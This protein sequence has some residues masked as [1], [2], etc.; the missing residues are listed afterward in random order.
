[1]FNK[2][3]KYTFLIIAVIAACS[4]IKI[5]QDVKLSSGDWT[6]AGGSPR[7]QNVSAY[8]LAPPLEL[9]WDYSVEGG[10]GPASMCIADAVLF[11]NTIPGELYTFDVS[12]GGK[13]GNVKF[14]GAD[15]STAPLVMGND[16][17]LTYAG[18]NSYSLAS[19]DVKKGEPSWRRNYGY[20]QTSPILKDSSVYFGSLKGVQYKVNAASGKMVWRFETKSPIHSTCAVWED[21]VIFGNDDGVI[22][23][24]GTAEG[25][26]KWKIH[27][28]L[29]VYSTPMVESG[30]AYLGCDDSNFYAINIAEGKLLWK[31]NMKTKIIAG[32]ALYGSEA[33]FGC[34]DGNIYSVNRSDG[35]IKWKFTTQGTV[36][37]SPVI[38]GNYIYCASYDSFVYCLDASTGNML[39]NKKLENKI[40]TSPLVWKDYLFVAAD[41]IVY[42]FTNKFE[43]EPKK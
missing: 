6:M 35:S 32:S 30:I 7:Q 5:E 4:G 14:L 20:I 34:V 11:V 33:V 28:R 18:D 10:V 12:T 37:S 41:D 25:S 42:C 21:N 9:F 23:C 19:F 3:Y 38:S 26:E 1:M 29:P 16:I 40:K 31:N 2:L 15:A 39:W 24:L 13:L 22:Y 36:T 27:T 43:L 17:I 8:T